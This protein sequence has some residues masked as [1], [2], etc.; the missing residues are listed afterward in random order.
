LHLACSVD[1]V[2][3]AVGTAVS[4]SDS[5]ES[6]FVY[7]ALDVT[8]LLLFVEY[9]LAGRLWI[10]SGGARSSFSWLWCCESSDDLM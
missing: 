7:E 10:N 5:L 2:I 1:S 9:F 3:L 8:V 6:V 4:K